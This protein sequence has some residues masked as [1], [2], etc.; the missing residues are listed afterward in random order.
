V[1]RRVDYCGSAQC[2]Q[3][4]DRKGAVLFTRKFRGVDALETR[5]HIQDVTAGSP[6][7]VRRG[8]GT[9]DPSSN[10]VASANRRRHDDG[11]ERDGRYSESFGVLLFRTMAGAYLA[12]IFWYRGYGSA[13]GAHAAY[14]VLLTLLRPS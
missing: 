5:N 7:S 10:I 6:S 11:S 4:R 3:S 1:G 2:N 9:D 13:A 8:W 14:N 12:V